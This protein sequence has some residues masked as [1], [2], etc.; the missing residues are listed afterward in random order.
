[1]I[2]IRNPGTLAVG[3]FHARSNDHVYPMR[4]FGKGQSYIQPDEP[5]DLEG[6]HIK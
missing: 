2:G 6:L 5:R 4:D 3:R 1:M